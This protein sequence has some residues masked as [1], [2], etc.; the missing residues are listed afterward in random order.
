MSSWFLGSMNQQLLR[1]TT[2]GALVVALVLGSATQVLAQLPTARLYS[3]Y[4][5]GG[6]VGAKVDVTVTGADLELASKLIFSNPAITGAQKTA[7]PNPFQKGPQPVP[8]QFTITIPA[9]CPPGLYEV[10]AVGKFGVSNARVFEVGSL[11]EILEKEPNND[12]KTATETTLGSV[13]NGKA[14]GAADLDLFQFAARQGQRVLIDC[15]AQRLDSRMDATLVLYNP[16]GQQIAMNRDTTRRDPLIDFT[17]PADG[18]YAV[19]VYDF[20]YGG[21]DD[22]VYRLSIG[23]GPRIDFVYPPAGQAGTTGAFTLYGRNLPGGAP[24]EGVTID[25]RPLEKLTV[26]IA[27]PGGPGPRQPSGNTLLTPDASDLDA[28]DYRLTTPQGISNA[29]LI[30][31]TNGPV[32][33]E[34]EPNDISTAAQKIALPCEIVGQF[35]KSADMDRFAFEGKAGTAYWVEVVAHRFG[36]MV[37]PQVVIQRVTVNDK[38]EETV[39]DVIESDD[40]RPNVGG[41]T[42]NTLTE[43]PS[44]AFT[45]PADGNYRML[46]KNQFGQGDPRNVYR[47]SIHP[48][49]PD[50]RLSVVPKFPAAPQQPVGVWSPL[51]RKGGSELLEVIAFREDGF[52]GEIAVSV[53]GLPPGVTAAPVTIGT[54][55]NSAPLVLTA[56]DNAAEW[57]GPVKVVGKAKV[58]EAEV[59]REARFGSNIWET[60]TNVPNASAPAR[61]TQSLMLAISGGEIADFLVDA[62]QGKVWEMS[63]AGALEI[64]IK[65]TRRGEFKGAVNLAPIGPPPNVQIPAIALNP[66]QA[67]LPLK[68]NLPPNAPLGTFT[69]YLN[70]QTAVSYKRNPELAKAAADYKAELD[71][72]VTDLTEAMKKADADKATATTEAQTAA[73]KAK[74]TADAKTAADK[75]A[76]DAAAAAKAAQEKFEAAKKA[77][78]GDANNKTLADA[79]AAAEKEAADTAAKAKTADEAKVAAAKAAEEAATA[80]KTTDEKKAAAEKAAAAAADKLKQAQAVQQT[81]TQQAQQLATAANPANINVFVP[82]TPITLKITA[83]PI[84]SAVTAPGALK[85]GAEVQIPV[86]ITRLYNYNDPVDLE[87]VIPNGVAGLQIAKVTIAAGANQ[88]ALVVKAA[89]NATVGKHNLTIR[90]TAKLNNQPLPVDQPTMLSVEAP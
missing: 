33:A 35:Q 15:A 65:I 7:E 76:A 47:V 50:F 17:I 53:E 48:A 59:A 20:T 8:N 11:P 6:Q 5:A 84:T 63:R 52:T 49:A 23:T 86:T 57:V 10:R 74:T 89:A 71:K 24:A 81:A 32:T 12:L 55:M 42:F 56:A 46:V 51:L 39:A 45:V 34:V 30:G 43:D 73:A 9:D 28:I 1:R 19:K 16:A 2:R 26:Q 64:P 68:F 38:G 3:I 79:K 41:A 72:A 60:A 37:D 14:N 70:G 85:Q 18:V 78:D 31:V 87:A 67:E 88:G 22:F 77:A 25:G 83:S 21:G 69:F 82:S 90:A 4:P 62:G 58:A 54:G 44:F 66:D 36:R 61:L 40:T 29:V 80:A 27:L 75:A 13:V